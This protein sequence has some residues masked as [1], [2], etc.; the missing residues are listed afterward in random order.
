MYTHIYMYVYIY[1]YIHI[2]TYVRSGTARAPPWSPS[3][4]PSWSAC[5]PGRGAPNLTPMIIPAKSC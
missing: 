4:R 2:Y 3:A 1:I 5:G